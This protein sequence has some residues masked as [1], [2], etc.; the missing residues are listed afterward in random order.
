MMVLP[1]NLFKPPK[2]HNEI[3]FFY[4]DANESLIGTPFKEEEKT[5]GQVIGVEG[6]KVTIAITDK[7]AYRKVIEKMQQPT[8]SMGCKIK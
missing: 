2:P 1:K 8:I 4:M 6:N 5:I 3:T 7:E